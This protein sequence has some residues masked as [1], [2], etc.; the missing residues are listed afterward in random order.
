MLYL[1]CI[2]QVCFSLHVVMQAQEEWGVPQCAGNP[3]QLDC[4]GCKGFKGVGICSHVLACN[5]LLK[6]FNVR[7]QLLQLSKTKSNNRRGG[8]SQYRMGVRPALTREEGAELDSSDEEAEQLLRLG[9][10]GK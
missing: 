8:G 7:Y 4:I 9:E 6:Q 1:M 10:E 5:H 2:A 3:A